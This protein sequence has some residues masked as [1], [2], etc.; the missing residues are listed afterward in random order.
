[1][2][3]VSLLQ[4]CVHAPALGDMRWTFEQHVASALSA[5]RYRLHLCHGELRA[6]FL[7]HELPFPC[8]AALSLLSTGLLIPCKRNHYPLLRQGLGLW[9]PQTSCDPCSKLSPLSPSL[10]PMSGDRELLVP[11]FS[12][13]YSPSRPFSTHTFTLH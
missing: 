7:T 11:N 5:P 8:S 6:A 2:V 4:R 10:C 9:E 1:M 13:L 3:S 12:F